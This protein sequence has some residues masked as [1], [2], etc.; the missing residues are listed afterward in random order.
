MRETGMNDK[1]QVIRDT[2]DDARRQ[3]RILLRGSRFAAIGVID[4]ETGFPFVSRVLLGMDTDGAAVIW[5]R[6]SRRTRR[7]CLPIR[8]PRS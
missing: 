6:T 1:P 4:P 8:A 2:D 3:A 7:H 5:C